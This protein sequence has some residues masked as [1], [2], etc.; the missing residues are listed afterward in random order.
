MKTLKA[1]AI[2]EYFGAEQM[3]N[4]NTPFEEQDYVNAI[5]ELEELKNR[6]CQNCKFSIEHERY[7]ILICDVGVSNCK[8]TFKTVD[9]DFSCNEWRLK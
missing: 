9:Y 1:I 6:K 2:L 8:D 5:D 4:N 7:K 3:I